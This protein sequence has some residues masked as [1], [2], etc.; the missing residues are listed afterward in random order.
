MA[1][2]EDNY[3][4]LT[5]LINNEMP[6]DTAF[7]LQVDGLLDIHLRIIERTR[8]TT[9]M[10]LTYLLQE[11]DVVH[12]LPDIKLRIYHDAR[13]A[14]VLSCGRRRGKTPIRYD[15]TREN[16]DLKHIWEMNRF[17][18]KWLAY[19]FRHGYQRVDWCKV[20]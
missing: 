14:E 11:E 12:V 2:Y 10:H 9:V 19:C 8:F 4:R 7:M 15:R 18:Q 6:L 17:L 3:I 16:Y 13:L 20:P 5:A 1:I